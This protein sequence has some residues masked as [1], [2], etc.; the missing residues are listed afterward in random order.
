MS[1]TLNLSSKQVN[2]LIHKYQDYS[3][4][5]TNNYT[6]FRAKF[7]SSTL[8]IYKTNTLLVQGPNSTE[9]FNKICE[10]LELNEKVEVK[11]KN[12]ININ[13][14][15]IGTDEVGTGDFF[16]PIV[17]AAAFVDKSQFNKLIKLGIKDSKQLT[18]QKIIQI[19]P[20]IMQEIKYQIVSL[21]NVK[22]NY[23][24]S[25]ANYNMNKIK[26]LLHNDAIIRLQQKLDSYDSIIIDAFTTKDK[27]LD[28]LK[29]QKFVEKNV[30]LQEKGESK[31][32]SIACASI[33]ARYAFLHQLEKLSKE[34]G[35]DLPKG[36]S[37]K[38]DLAIMKIL[39]EYPDKY[40][41]KVGKTN[42]KNLDKAHAMIES[43]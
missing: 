28:Y 26:A 25:V 19:A 3:I 24:T 42:F 13:L 1:L 36:A 40:I 10:L 5:H 32:L 39:K 2:K 15:I 41:L 14:S 12:E 38:V 11:E 22:Y 6:L 43:N 9:L 37:N 18:D 21:D 23:L 16:G 31:Y 7:N 29:G 34:V 27:Y 4:S 17:V 8:T 35:F 30:E 20:L 33:I